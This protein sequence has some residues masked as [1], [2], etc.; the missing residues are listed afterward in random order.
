MN[1]TKYAVITGS[2]K[3][4][5]REIGLTLLEK[6]YYVI[7]NYSKSDIDALNLE[8]QIKKRYKNS[9]S[10][11]KKDLSNPDSV[12]SI[13][14]DILKITYSLDVLVFNAGIT[15]RSNFDEITFDNW[16]KVFNTNLNVPF[17]ILKM[18]KPYIRENGNVI[19]IGSRLGNTP[20]SVSLSYGISKSAI[21]SMVKNLVKFFSIS[22]IRINGIAPGFVDTDWQKSKTE[23]VR[24]KILGKIALHRFCTVEEIGALAYHI[25]ENG[26]INGEVIQL[27]GGYNFE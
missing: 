21:H 11:I 17:F 22:G 6:G 16:M 1:T 5:G 19:F 3:G 13:V 26:Y 24:E 18:L 7:F 9:F 14:H 12:D 27:D 25:I 10:I 4:I 15:D 23:I 20:H 8:N 2:T